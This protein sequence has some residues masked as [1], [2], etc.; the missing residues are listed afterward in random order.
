MKHKSSRVARALIAFAT[1]VTSTLAV[2]AGP[3]TADEASPFVND[4]G[5]AHYDRCGRF[6]PSTGSFQTLYEPVLFDGY[7]V[8]L[9]FTLTVD[10]IEAL[11]CVDEY[12]ELDFR[13]YGFKVPRQWD[14]YTFSSNLPGAIHDVATSDFSTTE[15]VPAVTGIFVDDLSAGTH[16][17]A[18]ISF[19]ERLD[20]DGGSPKVSIDW[21]PS[22][23]ASSFLE[24][25]FC[26]AALLL[27]FFNHAECIFGTTRVFL[28]DGYVNGGPTGGSLP[29]DGL[30]VW[31]FTPATGPGGLP[32][33][34]G[35]EGG[36]PPPPVAHDP[37]GWLDGAS[38]VAGGVRFQGW[39][40]DDDAPGDSVLIQGLLDGHISGH[41]EAA[42]ARSDVG[43]HGFDFV[44][45][46]DWRSY[47]ACA[48]A[49]NIGGGSNV[50]LRPGCV[51]IP[52]ADCP[53]DVIPTILGTEADDRI[54]GTPGNDV[55]WAL[56]G[57][58]KVF[59]FGG[60]DIVCGG[61]GNDE[62][63]AT[64]G[65][66]LIFGGPGD[67]D[68]A[69]GSG[70]NQI[71]TGNGHDEVTI[72]PGDEIL[73]Q[74]GVDVVAHVDA[75]GTQ[76]LAVAAPVSSSRPTTIAPAQDPTGASGTPAPVSSIGQT[77][78]AQP[79]DSN[80]TTTTTVGTQPASV[81]PS[82]A[83]PPTVATP[84]GTPVIEGAAS[85]PACANV[86]AP[87]TGSI[88]KVVGTDANGVGVRP[89]P[90][91]YYPVSYSLNEGD[92]VTVV[93]W[94]EGVEVNG[95]TRWHRLDD[96]NWVPYSYLTM[97]PSTEPPG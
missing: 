93:C 51:R 66:G 65:R 43:P 68:I 2:F 40:I 69:A 36:G 27:T 39:A 70:Q 44:V 16:Y 88:Y 31:E 92:R 13:L 21:V 6:W 85:P 95:S 33:T 82:P 81:P 96:G 83:D 35:S 63:N 23:W 86:D 12:L 77:D 71:I 38:R 1:V 62:I 46:S 57:N 59:G 3:A 14:G 29:F 78:G 49:E 52:F 17:Y 74:S 22:H 58:D 55:I 48:R 42:L 64:R 87:Q 28:S 32:P 80:S 90:A 8:T 5:R 25:E 75:P 67:D 60:N 53:D 30:R 50:T 20:P 41:G 34:D 18:S 61:P 9:G 24:R 26:G 73:D 54:V 97:V 91:P 4:D 11:R 72:A 89:A 56:G 84:V 94:M 7:S 47:L 37:R 76:S 15:P 45:P 79:S 19:D 10:E